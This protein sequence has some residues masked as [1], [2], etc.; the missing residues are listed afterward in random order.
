M[1]KR[2]LL[3]ST[4]AIATLA[5]L[6]ACGSGAD[7]PDDEGDAG[8]ITV[9]TTD[10]L[11]DRVAAT[12]AII[13]D[14]T[15]ASGIEVD[16]VGVPEDQ[17]NQQLTSAA[18]AGD[19]PDVIGSVSL[20]AVRTLAANDL[21]DAEAVAGV[22]ETLGRDT[23]NDRA[24]EMVRDGE[25]LL[26][27]PGESWLQLLY[28]R[29]D[30]F[31]AAGLSAPET[32]EDIL[33]AAQALDSPEVAGF[34]GA[35]GPGQNFT[36]QTFEEIALANNCQIV[37]DAG[38]VVF[39]SPECVE[40]LQFYGDLISTYS[41]PGAQDVDTVRANYFAGTAAM[42]IWSTFMLDELAGLRDDAMPSCAECVADPTFLAANTGVVPAIQGPSGEGPAQ[43]AQ[44]TSWTIPVEAN[45]AGAQEFI[46]FM[47]GD[48]YI[49]WLAIAPEGKYPVR[50]GTADNPTEFTDAWATLPAG[51]DRTA[52]LSEFY[53]PE[54][55]DALA[56]GLSNMTR[57][58][59]TQGQG[60]LIG[61]VA[62]EMPIA[63][64]VS[65]VTSG[66]ASP[67]DAAAT[68]AEAI[69]EIQSSLP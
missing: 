61:A 5:A 46:A 2:A 44:V 68:A 53:G 49:D 56:N 10:T 60:D 52:P 20:G 58:G 22:I 54:V 1:R 39:D 59:I 36:E 17:F 21:V 40:A 28:Y 55:L 64:A 24:L 29:T 26:A 14:F 15:A 32:Y 31:D 8:P 45:A 19:L 41:V 62:G 6:V 18:A 7:T 66:A 63:T 65:D 3:A 48:G 27:V 12:E 50:T 37:D 47:L 4:A 67:E 38:E 35:T 57:W 16:L 34:V 51:V 30:L 9:W 33:A 23:F 25:D 11:P 69:R 13:A 43:F 42:A